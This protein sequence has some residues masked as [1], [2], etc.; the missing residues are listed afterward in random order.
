M[1][2]GMWM[3]NNGHLCQTNLLTNNN[4]ELYKEQRSR[5]GY[6]EDEVE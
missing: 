3:F 1:Y 5:Y 2:S 4:R 6:N